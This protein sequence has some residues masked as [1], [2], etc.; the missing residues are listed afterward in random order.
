MRALSLFCVALLL[1]PTAEAKRRSKK[2]PP[3]PC[4]WTGVTPT[5]IK[6]SARKVVVG[7]AVFQVHLTDEQKRLSSKMKACGQEGAGAAVAEWQSARQLAVI[8][9]VPGAIV[10]F[11]ALAMPFLAADAVKS[12]KEVKRGLVAAVPVAM[13]GE[14]ARLIERTRGG[15]YAQVAAELEAFA[16]G[17]GSLAAWVELGLRAGESEADLDASVHYLDKALATAE[18]LSLSRAVVPVQGARAQSYARLEQRDYQTAL[19]AADARAYRAYLG[20]YPDGAHVAD[21]SSRLTLFE[22]GELFQAARSAGTLGGWEGFLEQY[23]GSKRREVVHQAIYNLLVSDGTISQAAAYLDRAATYGSGG[24]GVYIESA[25]DIL[26]SDVDKAD[27]G[28]LI[29]YTNRWP[30]ASN[31]ESAEHALLELYA[32]QRGEIGLARY[33]K[34]R[35]DSTISERVWDELLE[36][37]YGGGEAPAGMLRFVDRYPEAPDATALKKEATRLLK[38][39]VEAIGLIFD[40]PYETESEQRQSVM[41]LI[42][43]SAPVDVQTRY[44]SPIVRVDGRVRNRSDVAV[45]TELDVKLHFCAE[46]SSS[47]GGVVSGLFGMVSGKYDAKGK[48]AVVE[49]VEVIAPARGEVPFTVYV[50]LQNQRVCDAEVDRVSAEVEAVSLR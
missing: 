22:E 42:E 35:G 10:V 8:S 2:Q 25:Y 11:P 40:Q 19:A 38:K 7:D 28:A 9:I 12:R 47:L 21:I 4:E 37:H 23:P 39:N 3:P 1:A 50:D 44:F 15:S 26:Y 29:A 33:L 41:G 16:S 6:L 49:S 24:N 20:K 13:S 45:R 5:A 32:P 17:E 43:G 30:K 34:E 14:E 27:A 31:R 46:I 18:R 48:M 36:R